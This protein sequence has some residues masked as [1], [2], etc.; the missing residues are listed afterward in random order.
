MKD[1]EQKL[2]VRKRSRKVDD[3]L[4]NFDWSQEIRNSYLELDFIPPNN[5]LA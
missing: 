5:N 2:L 4:T 1:T 3:R